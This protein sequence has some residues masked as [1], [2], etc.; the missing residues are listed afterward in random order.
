MRILVRSPNWIGDQVLAFP[1]YYALRKEFP[2]AKITAACVPW[3]RDLQFRDLVDEV[4]VLPKPQDSSLRAKWRALEEGASL[5]KKPIAGGD[6]W[7]LAFVLPNSFSSAYLVWRAGAKVRRGYA[8]E[9]RSFLLTDAL[10]WEGT[11]SRHRAQ[12][13][14]DLLPPAEGRRLPALEFWGIPAENPLDPP[15]P[16]EL[17]EFDAAKSWPG[18]QALSPPQE[19]YW[20]LAPG[21]TAESRRWPMDRFLRLARQLRAEKGWKGII[22][23]GPS[24]APL[25][26]ELA[27]DPSTGLEDWTARAPV[28]SLA[29]LFKGAQFTLTNESGLAHVAS[30]C[31]SFVQIVCGAADPRRT[32]PVGPGYVQVAIHPVAC[33]PCERNTC[34]REG[35]GKIEC[36]TGQSPEQ[37]R[38]EIE[39]GLQ[40]KNG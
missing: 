20:V 8:T 40:I 1:F 27:S 23:G 6:S 26:A 38:G 7:D 12:A 31:G 4:V 16:G 25:G 17:R 22:V 36:L 14:L 24:E 33:W 39:R 34:A 15:I 28:P 3:V 11:P 13:Y 18:F 30:L 10:A 32:R 9:G 5:L 2:R 21:A 29:P 35:A 19:P 37:I